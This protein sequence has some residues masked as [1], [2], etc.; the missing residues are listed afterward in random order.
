MIDNAMIEAILKIA[1]SP[2]IIKLSEPNICFP[3][4]V[5]RWMVLRVLE[6]QKMLKK[7]KIK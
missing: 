7:R 1:N 2:E 6:A 5:E 3:F 4:R